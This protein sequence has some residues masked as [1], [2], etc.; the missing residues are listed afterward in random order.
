MVEAPGSRVT[1]N[2]MS[3][4]GDAA[5]PLERLPPGTVLDR[6]IVMM[7]L[8]EGGAGIV[9]AAYDPELDRKVALKLVR[10]SQRTQA[11]LLR[12]AQAMA[13]LS[14]PNVVAAY[15]VGTFRDR[16]FV[17]MEFVDGWTL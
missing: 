1:P 15:D 7:P 12:E 3:L 13:R 10:S 4:D 6:Y 2:T 14:H 9:Y 17:A 8:G 5:P 11:R 16:V